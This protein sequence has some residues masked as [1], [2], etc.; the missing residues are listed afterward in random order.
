VGPGVAEGSSTALPLA[1]N[2]LDAAITVNTVYFVPDLDTACVE[3]ARVVRLGGR[4]V[5]RI[6]SDAMK[7]MPFTA[8]GFTLR[9][10]AE[11]IAALARAGCTVEHQQLPNPPIPHHLLVARPA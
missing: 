6:G 2:S 10:V 3:L 4:L 1:D 8:Y 9:P 7:K 5:I 11:V